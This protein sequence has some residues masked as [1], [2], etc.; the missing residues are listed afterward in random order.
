[1]NVVGLAAE[2]LLFVGLILTGAVACA[3][4]PPPQE[5]DDVF[6]EARAQLAADPPDDPVLQLQLEEPCATV[7]GVRLGETA[8]PV[9]GSA[10]ALFGDAGGRYHCAWSTQD[11]RPGTARLEVVILEA[12]EDAE[13]NR[14]LVVG[15]EGNE[16]VDTELGD[17]HVASAVPPDSDIPVMVAI[18]IDENEPGLIQ[19]N[20]QVIDDELRQG[21]DAQTLADLMVRTLRDAPS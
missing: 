20:V 6:A 14:E 15:R 21:F 19:F 2:R 5:L 18:L 16:V 3:G 9:V 1:M 11:G 7:D 17:V 4:G 12:T 10:T 13:A 8:L